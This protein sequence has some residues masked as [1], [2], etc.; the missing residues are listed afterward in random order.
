[1]ILIQSNVTYLSWRGPIQ[2]QCRNMSARSNFSTSLERMLTI[3]PTELSRREAWLS[4]RA[5]LYSDD[6]NINPR[7][8][9]LFTM[10]RT[11]NH[12]A[13][14]LIMVDPMVAR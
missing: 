8:R 13:S 7:L 3:W 5:F 11:R 1:M 14:V 12:A 9:E 10:A 2:S 6:Q 4:R